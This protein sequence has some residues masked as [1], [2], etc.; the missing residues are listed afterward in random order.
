MIADWQSG[1]FGGTQIRK[2]RF[3]SDSFSLK[4]GDIISE[5]IEA[6]STPYFAN[7]IKFINIYDEIEHDKVTLDYKRSL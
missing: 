2:K 5:D 1:N 6:L 7:V 3:W 4:T